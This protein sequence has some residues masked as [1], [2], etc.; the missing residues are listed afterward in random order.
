L[1]APSLPVRARLA[2]RVMRYA[3]AAIS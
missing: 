1:A 3:R 2:A